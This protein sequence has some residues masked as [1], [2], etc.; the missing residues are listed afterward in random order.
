MPEHVIRPSDAGIQ[1][2]ESIH[3]SQVMP[4]PLVFFLCRFRISGF[5]QKLHVL[6]PGKV[7][8]GAHQ[9]KHREQNMPSDERMRLLRCMVVQP[10]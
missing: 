5:K 3:Q 4:K 9:S 1:N 2:L 10:L 6:G 7:L 8:N